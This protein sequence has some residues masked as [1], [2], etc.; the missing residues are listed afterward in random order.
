M[1]RR[2]ESMT[3]DY[4]IITIHF[5]L[6]KIHTRIVEYFLF[7]FGNSI[8]REKKEEKK[9]WKRSGKYDNFQ[10]WIFLRLLKNLNKFLQ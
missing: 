8:E 2:N 7:R 6:S 4:S 5:L 3:H 1:I 10:N 9:T